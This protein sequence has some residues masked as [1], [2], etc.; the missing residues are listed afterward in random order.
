MVMEDLK[1]DNVLANHEGKMVALIAY[2][3][4][5][6]RVED[7]GDNPAEAAS[8]ELNADLE[9]MKSRGAE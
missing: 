7:P 3:Q 1:K 6:G 4:S 9:A 2:L 8:A 5:L